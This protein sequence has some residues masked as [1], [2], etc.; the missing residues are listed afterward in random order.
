LYSFELPAF[1]AFFSLSQQVG[2]LKSLVKTPEDFFILQRLLR[3]R[4]NGK[5]KDLTP[6][7]PLPLPP[8]GS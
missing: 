1:R 2:K 6:L 7:P 3:E 8:F 4:K 5:N